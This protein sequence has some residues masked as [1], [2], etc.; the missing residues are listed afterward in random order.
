MKA[1]Q[2]REKGAMAVKHGI[3]ERILRLRRDP[4]NLFYLISAAGILLY[5]LLSLRWGGQLYAWMVQENAPEIRFVDY[6][7]HLADAVDRTAL[8]QHFSANETA[9]YLPL[10]PPLAYCMYHLLFRLTAVSDA[11]P[12]GTRAAEA[13]PG[14]LSVFTIFLIFTAVLFFLGISLTG[15]SS[16]KKDLAIFT[17]LMLSAV[18]GGSGYM[19][20][21][22]AM[23]V[24]ALLMLGLHLTDSS[25]AL[26]REAGLL[27]LAVCVALKIYPAVFG[28]V[29]LKEKKYRE[30]V[31]F[32]LYS[33]LLLFVPFVFFGGL[34]ALQA[35][36]ANLF[37]PL[38][39]SDF[40]RLQYLKGIFFTLIRI[41]TG[42][43]EPLFSTALSAAVCLLWVWLAW[44]SRSRQRTLFFLTC[45]MVFFP[46][47]SFR[48]TL[49][50]FAVP[51]VL[52]LKEDP[53]P[54][55]RARPAA[56][57]S[58][59]YGLLYTVPVWWLL[60]LPIG[61][62]FTVHT[63]T[64]VEIWLYLAAYTLVA[65]MMFLELRAGWPGRKRA[66][67]SSPSPEKA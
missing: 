50:Y 45:V 38:A 1:P 60:V 26:R 40:G 7:S 19:T 58:G 6:F 22:S 44:R 62:R 18:F 20:G 49:A 16:R 57:L 3:R 29:L 21:N 5:F 53:E 46:S 13:V 12:E 11:P 25:G 30:L 9:T 2:I 63:L 14:A 54:G 37:Y 4:R 42:R 17:L 10:F 59:L 51:L 28:L 27:L 41:L 48:Y 33:L 34:S 32:I 52:L 35:W 67:A 8:Y 23:L 31:R 64:S 39:S 66:G 15:K 55:L 43:E 61:R 36:A 24:L 65:V 47:N 56:L